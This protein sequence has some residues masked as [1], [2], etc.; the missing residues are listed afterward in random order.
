MINKFKPNY[1][2]IPLYALGVQL[3][4]RSLTDANSVWYA[5]LI[6]PAYMPP[7]WVFGVVWTIIFALTTISALIFWNKAYG[8]KNFWYIIGMFI[9]NSLFNVGWSYLFFVMHALGY[10]LLR[11]ITLEITVIGLITVLWK[12][13][14]TAS[15][16]LLPYALWVGFAIILNY[17]I[18]LLN[19]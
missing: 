12:Y 2:L 19:S 9:A 13:S 7:N 18:W 3:I 1:I 17:H 4:G 10:A 15:L 5:N 14:K 11:A 16:L 8:T 6:K